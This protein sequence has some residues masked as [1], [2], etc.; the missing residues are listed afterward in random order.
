[1]KTTPLARLL[2][3]AALLGLTLSL[4]L[5]TPAGFMPAFER[6]AV[7]IVACPGDDWPS[8]P[9]AHHHL[10]GGHGKLHEQCPFAAGSASALGERVALPQ[11]TTVPPAELLAYS[12]SAVAENRAHER[13]PLRGPPLPA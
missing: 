4:R 6:G 10:P 11:T 13:P 5:L 1:M 2:I 3:V 8:A 12:Y 9:L 7:R